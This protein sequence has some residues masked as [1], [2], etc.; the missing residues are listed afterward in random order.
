MK[1]IIANKL[2]KHISDLLL[3][4]EEDEQYLQ[5]FKELLEELGEELKRLWNDK[6]KMK[7]LIQEMIDECLFILISPLEQYEWD[8]MKADQ[9]KGLWAYAE[10]AGR[11]RDIAG[12]AAYS[13]N[14]T[15]RILYSKYKLEERMF[16]LNESL[17]NLDG[18]AY[19]L[20]NFLNVRNSLIQEYNNR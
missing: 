11:F 3:N 15:N 9:L 10:T 12:K 20:L 5:K 13:E 14:L 17:E 8:D 1:K 19:R 6:D 4:Q 7:D 2:D 16:F 18:M